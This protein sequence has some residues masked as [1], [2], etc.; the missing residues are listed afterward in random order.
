[1]NQTNTFITGSAYRPGSR[2]VILA[3]KAY[4]RLTLE[5]EPENPFEP[6]GNAIKVLCRGKHIGYIP[7]ADNTLIASAIDAG[8][9]VK[10]ICSLSGS[11]NLQVT[12]D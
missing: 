2:A 3:L 1:M 11:V 9:D 7:K 4:D 8:K 10:A 5:R 12:W 6:N